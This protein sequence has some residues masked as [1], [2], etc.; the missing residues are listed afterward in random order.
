MLPSVIITAGPSGSTYNQRKLSKSTPAKKQ[1]KLIFFTK[2]KHGTFNCFLSPCVCFFSTQ[3][4]YQQPWKRAKD[5]LVSCDKCCRNFLTSFVFFYLLFFVGWFLPTVL[6]VTTPSAGN[7]RWA[8][9]IV[10]LWRPDPLTRPR[11]TWTIS[12]P[13]VPT[14]P[15]KCA[16]SNGPRAAFSKQSTPFT[17]YT[18][19]IHPSIHSVGDKVQRPLVCHRSKRSVNNG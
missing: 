18:Q 12:R 19:H 10:S 3:Q 15:S 8:T 5:D 16:T 4:H 17:R 14:I 11:R 13:T 9:W 1:E 2:A 7:V 6:P